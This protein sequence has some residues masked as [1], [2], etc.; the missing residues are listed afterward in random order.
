MKESLKMFAAALIGALLLIAALSLATRCNRHR[1]FGYYD[2][3][4]CVAAP[5]YYVAAP[6]WDG[7]AWWPVSF[8]F[9]WGRGG[10]GFTGHPGGRVNR[11]RGHR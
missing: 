6:A 2:A 3:P 1:V 9:T 4:A 11:G 5:A 10:R 8:R 7:P